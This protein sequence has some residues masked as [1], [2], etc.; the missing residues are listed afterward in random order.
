MAPRNSSNSSFW[1]V[2]NLMEER[3]TAIRSDYHIFSHVVCELSPE[4]VLRLAQMKV[5]P[6][7]LK[8]EVMVV[9]QTQLKCGLRLTFSSFLR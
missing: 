2:T 3:L 7:I 1:L 4:E 6:T 5:S 8:K 9:Y